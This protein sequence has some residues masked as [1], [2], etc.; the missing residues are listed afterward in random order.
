MKNC[1]AGAPALEGDS[2]TS[3]STVQECNGAAKK[4]K[5]G[6]FITWQNLVIIFVVDTSVGSR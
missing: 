6:V 2:E 3:A 5:G 1:V 4:K